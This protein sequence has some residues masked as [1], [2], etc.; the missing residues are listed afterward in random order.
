MYQ[1]SRLL[2]SIPIGS[3]LQRVGKKNYILIGFMVL[4]LANI[5][6]ACIVFVENDWVFFGFLVGLNFI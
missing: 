6:F 5:G 1:I 2:L 4:V 3:T